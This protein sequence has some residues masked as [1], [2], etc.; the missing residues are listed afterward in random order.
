MKKQSSM[1]RI[2]H[3][4]AGDCIAVQAGNNKNKD[5]CPIYKVL[6]KIPDYRGD[7]FKEVSEGEKDA[8]VRLLLASET[9]LHALSMICEY[10]ERGRAKGKPRI[11]ETW[12]KMA[13]EAIKDAT[14][15]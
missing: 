14:G 1:K 9:M 10:E 2:N 6:F 13:K 11:S 12:Y 8:T 7:S 5:N 3:F 4:I 15:K